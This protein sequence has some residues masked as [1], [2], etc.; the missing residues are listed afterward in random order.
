MGIP[1][2][3]HALN[4][5]TRGD[6]ALKLVA[7]AIAD[8]ANRVTGEGYPGYALIARLAECSEKTAQRKVDVLERLGI[9]HVEPEAGPRGSNLYRYNLVSPDWEALARPSGR[10]RGKRGMAGPRGV[11][12]SPV[13]TGD[14]ESPVAPT[15]DKPEGPLA[16]RGT[17]TGDKPEGPLATQGCPT[18]QVLTGTAIQP[19]TGPAFCAEPPSGDSAPEP[20]PSSDS[21]AVTPSQTLP[22]TTPRLGK[23]E[24]TGPVV[25]DPTGQL[26]AIPMATTSDPHF[27]V[28]QSLV[29]EYQAEFPML[30]VKAELVEIRRWNLDHPRQRKTREGMRRH[31]TSWLKTSQNNPRKRAGNWQRTRDLAVGDT[32]L[33]RGVEAIKRGAGI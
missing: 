2:I 29:D 23:N 3:N 30:D 31:I 12:G 25:L 4:L 21:A 11:S 19:W 8:C 9:V 10:K 33:Q 22:A 1:Q 28:R 20:E 26:L 7:A 16:T 5:D 15:G 6:Q 17:F 18:N 32:P 14:T 13:A 24:G 27:S